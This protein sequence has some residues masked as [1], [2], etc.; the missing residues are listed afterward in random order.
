ML[1]FKIFVLKLFAIDG[2]AT[3]AISLGEVTTLDHEPE[4]YVKVIMLMWLKHVLFDHAMEVTALVPE[5]LPRLS[6]TLL[7]RA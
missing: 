2:L 1:D 7:A 5:L 4:R 3:S 6:F